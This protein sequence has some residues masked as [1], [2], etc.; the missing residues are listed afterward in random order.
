MCL[1]AVAIDG[2]QAVWF[3]SCVC[4]DHFTGSVLQKKFTV[5]QMYL[6]NYFKTQNDIYELKYA[7]LLST[8]SHW[9]WIH[10]AVWPII[11]LP[12]NIEQVGHLGD[13]MFSWDYL[14]HN[15]LERTHTH[16]S[17]T[18]HSERD[19]TVPALASLAFW[20]SIVDE[21]KT[22]FQELHC[23]RPDKF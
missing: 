2:D 5:L 9:S 1:K 18:T 11:S 14:T 16:V 21:E 8:Y 20:S 15:T 17:Q 19:L 10:W 6:S 22:V 12:C 13:T 23:H 3:S 7:V 4:I